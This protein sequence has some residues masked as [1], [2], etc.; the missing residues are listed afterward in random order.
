MASMS[1]ALLDP[2]RGMKLIHKGNVLSDS[3]HLP[4]SLLV[5]VR[6]EASSFVVMMPPKSPTNFPTREPVAELTTTLNSSVEVEIH[7]STGIPEENYEAS[8]G[9]ERP[10]PT[11]EGSGGGPGGDSLVTGVMP[12]FGGDR[13]ASTGQTFE[14]E[15]LA[16]VSFSRCFFVDT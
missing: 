3:S 16:S 9:T 2:K 1:Q 10:P 15:C 7:A 5:A 4:T 13:G 6:E 11:S 8:R 12:V 14:G